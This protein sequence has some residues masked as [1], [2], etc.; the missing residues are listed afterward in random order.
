MFDMTTLV[1][2]EIC[3]DYT[4]KVISDVES[5]DMIIVRTPAIIV[6]IAV[7]CLTRCCCVNS[8]IREV[9]EIIFSHQNI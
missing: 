8:D 4:L 5:D 6:C 3:D 1:R 7:S 9:T 2:D